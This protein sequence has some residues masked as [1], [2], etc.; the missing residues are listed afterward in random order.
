[1]NKVFTNKGVVLLM[2]L[3]ILMMLTVI[4]TE[5]CY[6]MKTRVNITR[7]FKES[8]QA[9]YIAIA[10]FH[11]TIAEII[12]QVNTP[13]TIKEVDFDSVQETEEIQWRINTDIPA[14]AFGNGK[15]KVW[16][17]ND[18]GKVNINLADKG[19]LRLMLNG[20]DLEDK[21]KDVIV[22]SILDWKDAD[23]NH[24]INGAEDQYYQSL[25][26]PYECRDA[27]FD[28][29]EELLLVRG[30]TPDIFYDGLDRMITVV[31]AGRKFQIKRKSRKKR[32]DYN[33]LSMNAIPP[34]L[35][36]AFPGMTD[37]LVSQ[38]IEYRKNQDFGSINEL[39][40]IVGSDVYDGIY[41][42]LTLK[43]SSYFT[44]RSV[45]T[46][47]DSRIFEGVEAIIRVDNR[48]KNKYQVIQWKDGMTHYDFLKTGK[49]S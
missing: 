8:T 32:T 13:K 4:V 11:Q 17:D 36:R 28:S 23:G 15:Y 6:S 1:M 44:I 49:A 16:I 3:W 46:L 29:V 34:K 25:P 24:R 18:G 42:H 38:I 33:K 12:K 14:K 10:G 40:Q 20:F 45:G 7:N 26:D 41:R 19:L 47:Q 22:D 43:Q 30:V 5:F 48:I 31:P 21:E 27:D 35:W 37:D 9:Y 2:V 39:L